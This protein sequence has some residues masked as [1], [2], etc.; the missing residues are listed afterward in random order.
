MFLL[1]VPSVGLPV[2]FLLLCGVVGEMA[3]VLLVCMLVIFRKCSVK[4]FIFK[5]SDKKPQST[6][7]QEESSA[8]GFGCQEASRI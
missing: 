2:L 1:P 4:K 6:E 5:A 8:G 3:E 7:T